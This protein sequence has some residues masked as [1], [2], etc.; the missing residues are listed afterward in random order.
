LFARSE[1]PPEIVEPAAPAIPG[2]G[3]VWIERPDA[4][5]R[6]RRPR[7]CALIVEIT[8][9]RVRWSSDSGVDG[10]DPLDVFLEEFE[11]FA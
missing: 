6:S 9:T 11:P 7:L 8:E 10:D 5:R 4:D 1:A 3:R 2:P